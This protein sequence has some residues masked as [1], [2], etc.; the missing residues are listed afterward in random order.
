M[1][2]RTKRGAIAAEIDAVQELIG[3][4]ERRLGRLS[5]TAQNEASGVK[6]DVRDFVSD[7]LETIRDRVRKSGANIGEPAKLGPDT[8]KKLIDEVE[9]RPLLM[10][11]IAAGIGFIAGLA[12]TKR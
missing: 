4:L 11:G 12:N 7:A 2:S 5:G 1:T 3:D 6:N 10:L 8:L 9:N